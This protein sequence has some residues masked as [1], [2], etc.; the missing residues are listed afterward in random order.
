M[1]T[2]IFRRTHVRS[3][4]LREFDDSIS[5]FEKIA[6][7]LLDLCH[8]FDINPMNEFKRSVDNSHELILKHWLDLLKRTRIRLGDEIRDE[9]LAGLTKDLLRIVQQYK[10]RV[11]VPFVTRANTVKLVMAGTEDRFGRIKTQYNDLVV[12]INQLVKDVNLKLK[13]EKD[14]Q[15]R[16]EK[17]SE[18][19]RVQEPPSALGGIS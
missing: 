19:L 11:I 18:E 13:L 14:I 8:S 2:Y 17:I 3:G 1:L 5:S 4:L 6:E 16:A 10:E 7:E 9:T 12:E 15:E